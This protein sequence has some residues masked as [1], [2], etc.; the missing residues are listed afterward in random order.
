MSLLLLLSLRA[1]MLLRRPL[2]CSSIMQLNSFGSSGTSSSSVKPQAISNRQAPQLQ[3]QQH[4]RCRRS[5]LAGH[6]ACFSRHLALPRRSTFHAATAVATADEAAVTEDAPGNPFQQLGVDVRLAVSGASA[7][8][9]VIMHS[10]QDAVPYRRIEERGM[11]QHYL[12]W[13]ETLSS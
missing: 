6:A 9:T 13:P 2:R 11:H 8:R 7:E 4:A 3:T 1:P 12:A 5:I 10:G